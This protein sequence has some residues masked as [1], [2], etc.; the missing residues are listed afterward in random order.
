MS[1]SFWRIFADNTATLASAI[2]VNDA[3]PNIEITN[4][5][6]R[7]W[8]FSTAGTDGIQFGMPAKLA[9]QED[10]SVFVWYPDGTPAKH[11]ADGLLPF[12]QGWCAGVATV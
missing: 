6:D 4:E 10:A 5:L 8:F 2:A 12:L 11:M 1:T 3:E 9:D 7:Y